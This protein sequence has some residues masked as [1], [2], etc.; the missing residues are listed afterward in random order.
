MDNMSIYDKIRRPPNE[1]LKT[2]RGGRLKGMTDINPMWRIQRLTEVFGPCGIGWKYVITDK[3][4]VQGGNGE[5]AAFV[6]INLYYK[7]GE[8]WSDGVP[9]TGGAS[10]VTK[11]KGGLY[12]SDEAYKMALTDAISVAAKALGMA[13]DI[14][15]QAGRTKY[16]MPEEE[17]ATDT[18]D[19]APIPKEVEAF[20]CARCKELLN[21]Y[22]DKDGKQVGVR[23]LAARTNKRFGLTLCFKCAEAIALEQKKQEQIESLKAAYAEGV[24]NTSQQVSDRA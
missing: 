20:R 9:G 4:I 13:A 18:T 24:K 7:N 14:Y 8:E 17:G 21:P 5:Q 15:W 19:T 1:A 3:Q 10:F 22:T 11:E 6:D 23:A 2:I 12:T 16:T